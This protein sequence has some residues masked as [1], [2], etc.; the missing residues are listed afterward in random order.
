MCA[1]VPCYLLARGLRAGGAASACTASS[2]FFSTSAWVAAAGA[3]RKNDTGTDKRS[4][5]LTFTDRVRLHAKGGAGGQVSSIETRATTIMCTASVEQS[6][7]VHVQHGCG[8]SVMVHHLYSVRAATCT[9]NRK[10]C[11]CTY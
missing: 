11:T 10:M 9:C 1:R 7:C 6:V 8:S 4:S 3:G 2:T 5:K